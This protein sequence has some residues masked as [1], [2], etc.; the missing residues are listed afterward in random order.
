VDV[1]FHGPHEEHVADCGYP[2]HAACTAGRTGE[3]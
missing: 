2:Q 1:I 3:H